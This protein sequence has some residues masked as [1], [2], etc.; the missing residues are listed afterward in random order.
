MGK[1]LILTNNGQGVYEVELKYG[2]RDLVDAK[3]A[4]LTARIAALQIEHDAMPETTPEEGYHLLGE[5]YPGTTGRK[6]PL[7]WIEGRAGR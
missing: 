4:A 1:G 6:R 2:G 7:K 3:I 5:A